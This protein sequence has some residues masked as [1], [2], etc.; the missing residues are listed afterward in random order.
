MF[1]ESS[2]F[3]EIYDIFDVELYERNARGETWNFENAED[4]AKRKSLLS[5]FD[6]LRL[7]K[8]ILKIRR[9]GAV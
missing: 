6:F 4:F 1:Q 7:N 2:N 5:I 9:D 3:I 8:N